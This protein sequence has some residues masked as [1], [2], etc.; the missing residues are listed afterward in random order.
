MIRRPPRSTLSSSS[1]ASDVYKR[2]D[3]H[4]DWHG[5]LEDALHCERDDAFLFLRVEAAGV[6][7]ADESR[8]RLS[9]GLRD[10]RNAAGAG[11]RLGRRNER[12]GAHECEKRKSAHQSRMSSGQSMSCRMESRTESSCGLSMRPMMLRMTDPMTCCAPAKPRF[13]ECCTM[14]PAL[15]SLSGF[16]K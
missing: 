14:K 3:L 10:R 13:A 8:F 6:G 4:L 12:D 15:A 16:M 7:G 1:A 9:D 2:Q 5:P 11:V